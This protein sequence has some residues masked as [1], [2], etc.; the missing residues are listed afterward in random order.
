MT[1]LYIDELFIQKVIIP[2]NNT[3]GTINYM[4][5]A[6]A[7]RFDIRI[8]DANSITGN[9]IRYGKPANETITSSSDVCGV[10]RQLSSTKPST[11]FSE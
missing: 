5:V 2:V 10:T 7:T 4:D 6:G 1:D 11:N 3:E 8:D 9:S